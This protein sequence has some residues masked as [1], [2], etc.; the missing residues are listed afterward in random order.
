MTASELTTGLVETE[1]KFKEKL[2]LRN[3]AN[4]VNNILHTKKQR[5][6]FLFFCME[7]GGFF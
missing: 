2:S 3:T 1:S 4:G 7:L 6:S 5:N